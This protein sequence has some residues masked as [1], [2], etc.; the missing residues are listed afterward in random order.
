MTTGSRSKASAALLAV[1]G[2]ALDG[3]IASGLAGVAFL[4]TIFA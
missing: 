4:A 2:T 1:I 3:T